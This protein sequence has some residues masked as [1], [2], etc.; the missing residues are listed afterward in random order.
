MK[1]YETKWVITKGIDNAMKESKTFVKE[2]DDACGKYIK[3]DWGNL[4]EEDRVVNEDAI[5]YGGRVFASYNTVKGKIYIITE[6][7]RSVTTILFADE[8]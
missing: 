5:K 3:K 1:H 2:I 7:D 6:A 8:Y 4:C